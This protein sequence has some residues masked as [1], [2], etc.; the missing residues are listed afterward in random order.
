MDFI[1]RSQDTTANTS[2]SCFLP[3]KD[4]LRHK[5]CSVGGCSHS[6]VPIENCRLR[7]NNAAIVRNDRNA[8]HAR[9]QHLAVLTVFV[10]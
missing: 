7:H 4:A 9:A 5:K 3:L 2:V 10:V 6:L 1:K 8:V